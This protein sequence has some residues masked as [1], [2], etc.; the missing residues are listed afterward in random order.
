MKMFSSSFLRYY[1]M[2]LGQ[3]VA[4]S[5]LMVPAASAIMRSKAFLG[6][7]HLVEMTLEDCKKDYKLDF[8]LLSEMIEY[9]ILEGHDDKLIYLEDSAV[10]VRWG[11]SVLKKDKE[12]HFS[13]VI[14]DQLST[15]AMKLINSSESF[16]FTLQGDHDERSLV[17][18]LQAL[19]GCDVCV[20]SNSKLC[21]AASLCMPKIVPGFGM[22]TDRLW[23][24]ILFETN[25]RRV[26]E[27]FML[28]L[29]RVLLKF[30]DQADVNKAASMNASTIQITTP[31]PYLLEDEPEGGDHWPIM[32]MDEQ[33][34]FVRVLAVVNRLGFEPS[35]MLLFEVSLTSSVEGQDLGSLKTI[36]TYVMEQIRHRAARFMKANRSMSFAIAIEDDTPFLVNAASALLVSS[37]QG[38]TLYIPKDL[39]EKVCKHAKWGAELKEK[40]AGHRELLLDFSQPNVAAIVYLSVPE[41]ENAET[42]KHFARKVADSGA[43]DQNGWIEDIKET[44]FSRFIKVPDNDGETAI[45]SLSPNDNGIHKYAVELPIKYWTEGK[46]KEAHI[47]EELAKSLMT[48]VEMA[49]VLSA[50]LLVDEGG[51]LLLSEATMIR[52]KLTSRRVKPLC[53]QLLDMGRPKTEACSPEKVA[54]PTVKEVAERKAA[55]IEQEER[56]LTPL[57]IEG[58]IPKEG[59]MMVSNCA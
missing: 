2:L 4:I 16:S 19:R 55:L 28:G 39:S 6:A 35:E 43:A 18:I 31:V 11:S 48:E 42:K 25:G 34:G 21:H 56:R 23:N 22:V 57:T 49:E 29:G 45:I 40:M 20:P 41:H 53:K 5:L 44:A 38:E 33:G 47:D 3:L 50:L 12:G 14:K 58:K 32:I 26:E 30:A 24:S 36:V 1:M 10:G 8:M 51:H 59:K 17:L 27:F 52:P 54:V 37:N 13:G 9:E 7:G 46:G 15:N